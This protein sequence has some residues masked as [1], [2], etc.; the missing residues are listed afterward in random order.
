MTIN[1]LAIIMSMTLSTISILGVV[2]FV[3]VKLTTLQIK[4]DTMWGVYLRRAYTELVCSDL[5]VRNS[6][7]HLTDSAMVLMC[8]LGKRFFL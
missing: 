5:G 4:V 1:S 7:L 3:G 8:S 2:Y 6:P